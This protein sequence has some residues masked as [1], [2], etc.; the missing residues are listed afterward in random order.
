[1][2][3]AWRQTRLLSVE[4][5]D[6][7]EGGGTAEFVSWLGYALIVFSARALGPVFPR[8]GLPLITGY[9]IVGAIA[10]PYLVHLLTTTDVGRLSIVTDFALAFIAFSAGAELYMPELRKT[11]KRIAYATTTIC[12]ISFAITVDLSPQCRTAVSTVI[13]SIM[14]ARSPASAIA[15]IKELK[16]HGPFVSSTL[17]ITVLGDLFVLVA[18]S[19]TVSLASISCKGGEFSGG[20]IGLTIGVGIIASIL[21]GAVIGLLLIAMMIPKN[22]Y[23]HFVIL[24]FGLAIFVGCK[25]LKAWTEES[26]QNQHFPVPLVLTLNLPVILES[27]GFAIIITILRAVSIFIGAVLVRKTKKKINNY[28]NDDN[29]RAP[30]IGLYA[31]GSRPIQSKF[32]MNMWMTLLTQAGVSLGLA[33]EMAHSFPLF[34]RKFQA[35]IVTIVFINQII[36]PVLFKIAVFRMGEAGKAVEQLFRMG[37]AA[38]RSSTFAVCQDQHGGEGFKTAFVI[39]DTPGGLAIAGRL[40][41]QGW[42]VK[43]L[44]PTEERANNAKAAIAEYG[45]GA[46]LAAQENDAQVDLA[47]LL[48]RHH[49]FT[50]GQKTISDPFLADSTPPPISPQRSGGEALGEAPHSTHPAHLRVA[51]SRNNTNGSMN[52]QAMAAAASAS[53]HNN[54]GVYEDPYPAHLFAP[55]VAVLS[56]D[57]TT[58]A[59]VYAL[60]NDETAHAMAKA[61]REA[62]LAAPVI[63]HLHTVRQAVMLVSPTWGDAMAALGVMPI[64]ANHVASHMTVALLAAPRKKPVTLLPATASNLETANALWLSNLETANAASLFLSYG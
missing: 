1:M 48:T 47:D 38:R 46:K 28:N 43:L 60:D 44:A 18:F 45:V 12:L 53:Q 62:V 39:G 63:S 36:G 31:A 54:A 37:E 3:S 59:V 5:D 15:V 34:G 21:L 30:P 6:T 35:T 41:A 64:H 40:L 51:R 19:I 42:H 11:I 25:E 4:T 29:P 55:F 20:V 8:F 50:E 14:M 16:A 26:G 49:E 2:S 52:S 23:F 56:E 27:L 32:N 9:L 24:P 22:K 58:A 33:A 7:S 61:V 10:G 17:G 13:G 57:P